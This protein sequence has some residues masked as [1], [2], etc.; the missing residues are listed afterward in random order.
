M[1]E[2][3]KS[4]QYIKS[5]IKVRKTRIKRSAFHCFVSFLSLSLLPSS[6]FQKEQTPMIN[7]NYMNNDYSFIKKL[8]TSRM[9]CFIILPQ[10]IS[11]NEI[12]NQMRKS[13]SSP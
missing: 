10:L 6:F 2:I 7:K 3:K 9:Y 8:Q 4:S 13:S 5:T 1:Y 12:N 11:M